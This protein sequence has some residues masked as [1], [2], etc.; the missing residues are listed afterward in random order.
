MTAFKT[1]RLPT[2][3]DAL[4]PDG[5]EVRLLPT[6]AGGSMAHFEL[7]SGKTSRPV[8]HRTV[9]EI[10]YFLAGRGEMWRKQDGREEV[11]PVEAGVSI[12]IP[13]GTHFQF[14]VLGDE[15]LAAVAVTIPPWPGEDEAYPVE[16]K[17]P[18]TV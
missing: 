9:D 18:P 16:G 8:G 7:A 12:T 13:L 10:W 15:P 6:L 4:A 11:V 17:W 2:A 3:P 14:R 1:A 5:A